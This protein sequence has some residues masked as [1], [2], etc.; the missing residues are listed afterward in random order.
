MQEFNT[1][2]LRL[3]TVFIHEKLHQTAAA[4]KIQYYN[5]HAGKKDQLQCCLAALADSFNLLC[6][7]IL[8]RKIRDAVSKHRKC[9]DDHVIEL[10]GCRISCDH[11]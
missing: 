7:K 5:R 1:D 11:I 2:L 9:R 8:C 3:D 4:Q 10:H 6:A